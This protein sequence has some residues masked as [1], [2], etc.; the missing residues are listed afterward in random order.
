MWQQ[1]WRS[2]TSANRSRSGSA[3]RGFVIDGVETL[4]QV[5]TAVLFQNVQHNFVNALQFHVWGYP[6]VGAA[7]MH[8]PVP[9]DPSTVTEADLVA[10]LP[11]VA[12]T[13]DILRATYGFSTQNDVMAMHAER[14]H[15]DEA[16]EVIGRF[17][18]RLDEIDQLIRTRDATRPDPYIVSKPS[19][20]P[21]NINA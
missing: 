9:A 11:T 20:I 16:A 17:Q 18:R 8:V 7:S 3:T 15:E 10:A 6:A 13:I 14:L 4:Q 1:T 5:V 12:Q 21:G 19:Q 2:P